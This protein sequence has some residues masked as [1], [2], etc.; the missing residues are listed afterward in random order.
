MLRILV[1][2]AVLFQGAP[3]HAGPIANMD[4][5]NMDPANLDPAAASQAEDEGPSEEDIA[6]A[7]ANLK[8]AIKGREEEAIV[9][10]C[11]AGALVPHDDVVQQLVKVLELRRKDE[12]AKPLRQAAL[13]AL[14]EIG[15]PSSLKALHKAFRKSK[16]L[17]KD[18]EL[19]VL[20][21]RSIANHE[22]PS[23][24]EVFGEG[25]DS[26]PSKEALRARILGLARIRT[27]ESIDALVNL[28]NR[29][30]KNRRVLQMEDFRLAFAVL[31]GIDRG[32]DATAWMR[33]WNDAKKTFE[34][35][36]EMGE[37]PKALMQRWR[38]FWGWGEEEKRG[39]RREDR[40][41]R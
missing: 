29:S 5:A 18:P 15:L 27:K 28:M 37:L 41:D 36:P 16:D 4:P 32:K 3:F 33:W 39:K 20:L 9:N 12:E 19:S 26:T 23:S 1:L 21:L 40:G 17:R 11:A 30:T 31:T 2:L 8:A 35:S 14:G 38:S 13:E 24:I 25:L 7:V 10:A 6:K 34:V 22:D